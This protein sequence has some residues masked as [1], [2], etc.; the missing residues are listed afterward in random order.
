MAC[1]YKGIPAQASRCINNMP[2]ILFAES[3]GAHDGLTCLTAM[4]QTKA[5]RTRREVNA[6][7]LSRVIRIVKRQS[8]EAE[9]Q[10]LPIAQW[11][12]NARSPRGLADCLCALRI[13]FSGDE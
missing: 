1:Q 6:Q 9:L 8:S 5:L 7:A 4:T 2:V 11:L 3:A 13:D 12:C 10:I